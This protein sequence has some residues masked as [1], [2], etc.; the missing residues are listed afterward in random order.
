MLNKIFGGGSAA[1]TKRDPAA[2]TAPQYKRPPAPAHLAMYKKAATAPAETELVRRFE[3]QRS[4]QSKTGQQKLDVGA[5]IKSLQRGKIPIERKIASLSRQQKLYQDK[6][7][8]CNLSLRKAGC[9]SAVRELALREK[10][11]CEQQHMTR[12]EHGYDKLIADELRLETARD[13]HQGDKTA[14]EKTRATLEKKIGASEARLAKA[15][16]RKAGLPDEADLRSQGDELTQ[17]RDAV[18]LRIAPLTEQLDRIE[19]AEKPL[20]ERRAYLEDKIAGY[21]KEQSARKQ[22]GGRGRGFKDW[23]SRELDDRR[24]E[25]ETELAQVKRSI[26]KLDND[27]TAVYDERK[28]HQTTADELDARAGKLKTRLLACAKDVA[29]ADRDIA[30]ANKS[31]R[32]ERKALDNCRQQFGALFEKIEVACEQLEQLNVRF[33]QLDNGPLKQIVTGLAEVQAAYKKQAISRKDQHRIRKTLETIEQHQVQIDKLG[34]AKSAQQKRI[35]ALQ[36]DEDGLVMRIDT[37]AAQMDNI[38][39][40]LLDLADNMKRQLEARAT[41]ASTRGLGSAPAGTGKNARANASRGARVDSAPPDDRTVRNYLATKIRASGLEQ[42]ISGI[43]RTE[44]MVVKAFQEA[45]A[46]EYSMQYSVLDMNERR[47]FF[48]YRPNQAVSREGTLPDGSSFSVPKNSP[49]FHIFELQRTM[50]YS[51]PMYGAADDGRQTDTPY[52]EAY[53]AES[54]PSAN[55]DA[56]DDARDFEPRPDDQRRR[57]TYPSADPGSAGKYDARAEPAP[58]PRQPGPDS[59]RTGTRERDAG[60]GRPDTD[61]RRA[62]TDA[63]ARAQSKPREEGYSYTY[64]YSFPRT[65]QSSAS[66]GKAGA[67][68]FSSAPSGGRA[69]PGGAYAR[70]FPPPINLWNIGVRRIPAAYHSGLEAI[71]W[72]SK[73]GIPPDVLDSF[74]RN[75]D[76]VAIGYHAYQGFC[77]VPEFEGQPKNLY[78]VM[79]ADLKEHHVVEQHPNRLVIPAG[80]AQYY[81]TEIPLHSTARAENNDDTDSEEDAAP[82]YAP[83]ERARAAYGE[84]DPDSD[85]EQA[86]PPQPKR[87]YTSTG[88]GDGARASDSGWTP[89]PQPQRSDTSTGRGDGARAADSSW[90]PPPQPKRSY[91]STGQGGGPRASGATAGAGERAYNTEERVPPWARDDAPPP[92]GA[93]ATGEGF[94]GSTGSR[95]FPDPGFDS[96]RD[97]DYRQSGPSAGPEVPEATFEQ[98]FLVKKVTPLVFTSPRIEMTDCKENRLK[99]AV[100]GSAISTPLKTSNLSET[101]RGGLAN[102]LN[103]LINSAEGE[104]DAIAG[105]GQI[106]DEY[107]EGQKKGVKQITRVEDMTPSQQEELETLYQNDQTE[108]L[109][110]IATANEEAALARKNPGSSDQKI[111]ER[112]KHLNQFRMDLIGYFEIFE[113]KVKAGSVKVSYNMMNEKVEQPALSGRRYAEMGKLMDTARKDARA[114]QSDARRDE[115]KKSKI[116]SLNANVDAEI[117]GRKI[118]FARDYVDH[119]YGNV[120]DMPLSEVVASTNGRINLMRLRT[121]LAA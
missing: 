72:V 16:A 23:S 21:K 22:E 78:L 96:E 97:D 1:S 103:F 53:S 110:T 80:G 52:A 112:H 39:R 9:S 71:G 5:E 59:A 54:G 34:V 62:R 11:L 2:V 120:F 28:P 116:A 81:V 41:A 89:P 29:D 12:T 113:G 35:D 85:Y 119:L 92:G 99:P 111:A 48:A 79:R 3:A 70:A 98:Q 118:A 50:A 101:Q 68:R 6:V 7:A 18:A 33:E 14:L 95:G 67:P 74:A 13:R 63:E 64:S 30:D 55:A 91:T 17:Q 104:I 82:R 45:H 117:T 19:R 15:S 4:E 43:D 32:A 93:R 47:T 86:P 114:K 8:A 65:G 108:T 100:I 37:V 109:K 107:V 87:S 115:I 46:S 88:R 66:A 40:S 69:Q 94:G 121:N 73:N 75:P 56:D 83:G 77:A 44:A 31:L 84:S 60:D 90:T 24:A 51:K 25:R 102:C 36:D 106:F 26:G 10:A 58:R 27:F 42:S 76:A 38:Q 105:F 57:S 20:L 61:Y 49:Y